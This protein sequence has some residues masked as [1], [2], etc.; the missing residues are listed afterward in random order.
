MFKRSIAAV[1]ATAC[2][3]GAVVVPA[4]AYE[5]AGDDKCNITYSEAEL[6]AVAKAKASAQV[7]KY[8][9]AVLDVEVRS[10]V[11]AKEDA[12][13][14]AQAWSKFV[15][16]LEVAKNREST[17]ASA[18]L[19]LPYA[20]AIVKANKDCAGETYTEPKQESLID[21]LSSGEVKDIL[22]SEGAKEELSSIFVDNKGELTQ[23]G[24]IATVVG[25]IGGL[26]LLTGVAGFVMQLLGIRGPF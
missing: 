18:E 23:E 26:G 8:A 24:I 2:L 3:T 5:V 6:N 25:V 9:P 13:K 12:V 7:A 11:V 16:I 20:K 17:K 10:G 22:S 21:A 19:A 14:I 1:A 15:E 4:Q